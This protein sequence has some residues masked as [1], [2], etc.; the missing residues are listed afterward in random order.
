M[1]N[2]LGY[3]YGSVDGRLTRG[4]L[5]CLRVVVVVGFFIEARGARR[6]VSKPV[7]CSDSAR[8]IRTAKRR[9]ELLSFAVMGANLAICTEVKFLK[10]S[11]VKI[12]WFCPAIKIQH[13]KMLGELFSKFY[14]WLDRLFVFCQ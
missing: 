8:L 11:F 3:G 12:S 1:G 10:L 2:C 14:R 4:S 9:L 5:R 13:L 7:C 6:S